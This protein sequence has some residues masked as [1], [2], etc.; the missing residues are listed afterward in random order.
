M[1]QLILMDQ[2]NA[3]STG[4]GRDFLLSSSALDVAERGSR[5]ESAHQQ[6]CGRGERAQHQPAPLTLPA[7]FHG[8]NS[9]LQTELPAYSFI[10]IPVQSWNGIKGAVF[11]DTTPVLC[12]NTGKHFPQ[13]QR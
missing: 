12:V 5:T 4:G 9:W 6:S 1:P 7:H 8:D 13:S 11:L 3:A 10:L 2:A